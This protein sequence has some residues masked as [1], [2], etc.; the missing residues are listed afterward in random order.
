MTRITAPENA[1]YNKKA[2]DD[3][4]KKVG[5]ALLLYPAVSGA[6]IRVIRVSSR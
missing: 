5:N 3:L 1:R 2:F 4:L 6:V